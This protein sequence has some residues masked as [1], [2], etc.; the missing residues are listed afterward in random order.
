M[1]RLSDTYAK[2][3]SVQ[4]SVAGLEDFYSYQWMETCQNDSIKHNKSWMQCFWPELAIILILLH[5]LALWFIRLKRI[6]SSLM[7]T[8]IQVISHS[9]ALDILSLCIILLH[10]VFCRMIFFFT[11]YNTHIFFG[12]NLRKPNSSYDNLPKIKPIYDCTNSF[13]K[14]RNQINFFLFIEIVY[15]R[16]PDIFQIHSVNLMQNCIRES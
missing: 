4:D 14:S 12:S 3:L 11:S 9:G 13:L 5:H 10:L 16:F 6:M 7:Q 1:G 2:S 15:R 8:L